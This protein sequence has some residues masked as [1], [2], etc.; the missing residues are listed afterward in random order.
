M[1]CEEQALVP[2]DVC[3]NWRCIE[4]NQESETPVKPMLVLKGEFWCCPK[5]H[6][7]YGK[8]AKK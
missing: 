5:C 3:L 7:S 1:S 8:N 4:W 6:A 2:T